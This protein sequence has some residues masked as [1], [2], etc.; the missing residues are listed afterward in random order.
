MRVGIDMAIE[1][2]VRAVSNFITCMFS[3]YVTSVRCKETLEAS[4]D[5]IQ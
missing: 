2:L 1:K 3:K 4:R 5:H